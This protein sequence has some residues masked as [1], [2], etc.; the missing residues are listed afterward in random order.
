MCTH[1]F[2]RKLI[3]WANTES[4]L[5]LS[6]FEYSEFLGGGGG[7]L[8]QILVG[9]VPSRLQEYTRPYTNFLKKYT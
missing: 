6:D 4:S 5:K 8:N 1:I 9:D 7:A 2:H 3:I